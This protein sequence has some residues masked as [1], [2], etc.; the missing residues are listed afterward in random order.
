MN[1]VH[2][3]LQHRCV[4]TRHVSRHFCGAK[5]MIRKFVI[6]LIFISLQFNF[7][8]AQSRLTQG[9]IEAQGSALYSFT[10]FSGP[11]VQYEAFERY[12]KQHNLSLQLSLGY[13]VSDQI[14]L[15]LQPQ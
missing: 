3:S 5:T 10:N 15:S 12:W 2:N 1:C 14:E 13:F 4:V 9:I 11:P 8:S 6:T 7:L